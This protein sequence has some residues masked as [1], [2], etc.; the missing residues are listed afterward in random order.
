MNKSRA[1][2][3]SAVLLTVAMGGTAMAG[4]SVSF[5]AGPGTTN[6]SA[7][8]ASFLAYVPNMENPAMVIDS[9]ISVSNILGAPDNLMYIVQGGAGEGGSTMMGTVEIYLYGMGG[10]EPIIYST[11]MMMAGQG[12]GMD[13]MLMP[14]GTYTVFLSEILMEAGH[15][16]HF[17]GYAWIVGNFDGIAGTRKVVDNMT[18]MFNASGDLSPSVDHNGG[19]IRTIMMDMDMDMDME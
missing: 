3:F 4:N 10:A 2:L 13:G 8:F 19:G 14:G 7:V 15:E 9:A 11:D 18:G 6:Q 12:T 17:L 16:G 1:M 5:M